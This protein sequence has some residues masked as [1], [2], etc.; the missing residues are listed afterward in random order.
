MG[1]VLVFGSINMDVVSLCERLPRAGET[2]LGKSVAFYPG[3]KGA[4]QA[5]AAARCLGQS[6][7]I[8]SVGPDDFGKRMLSYL[9]EN[10]VDVSGITIERELPTGVALINVDAQGENTIVVTPGANAR[11]KAPALFPATLGSPII[12][13]AQLESPVA[14]VTRLFTAV[15]ASRGR[16]ILNPSPYRPLPEELMQSTSLVIANEQEFSALAGIPAD[17]GSRSFVAG[18]ASAM[19]PVP[20]CV[21]TLGSAG[22]V[23]LE[24]GHKPTHIEAHELHAVDTTGAGD[25]FAGWLAAELAVGQTLEHAARRANAAAAISVTRP[26]AAPSMPRRSE[27]DEFLRRRSGE[28]HETSSGG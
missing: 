12:A 19:L 2:V 7:L 23:V 13:L 22:A 28:L 18:L 25:C 14:E 5:I 9:G 21:I 1:S 15:R 11:A 26:G 3:G 17:Q 16:T 10:L 20:C 27:V 24:Q 6:I 8:G 4:N